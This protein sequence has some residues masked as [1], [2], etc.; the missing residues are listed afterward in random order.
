M[1]DLTKQEYEELKDKLMLNEELSKILEMKIKNYSITKMSLEMN[2]SESSIKRRIKILKNK[3]LKL[4]WT[5]IKTKKKLQ[6]F[7]FFIYYNQK[8]ENI[9]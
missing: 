3:I 1:F 6:M 7:L 4:L 2:M 8:G 5:F 9:F